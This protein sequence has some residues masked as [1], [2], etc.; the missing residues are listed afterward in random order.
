MK[1]GSI[2]GRTII[3]RSDLKRW[4]ALDHAQLC[5]RLPSFSSDAMPIRVGVGGLV[6]PP[7]FDRIEKIISIACKTDID[8][9]LV[10]GAFSYAW[11]GH[12]GQ[13][14]KSGEPY[15]E[16]PLTVAEIVS[17]WGL[18][19][20]E[21]AA[22]L[23]HDLIE[24]GKIAYQKITRENI[25]EKLGS[26]I[27]ELVEGMTELGKE[28]GF[29]GEKPSEV[30]IYRKLLKHGSKDLGSIIVKLADRLH[31]MRT[32]KSAKTPEEKAESTLYVYRRIADA[33]GMW[34]LKR[35]FEDL[36]FQWLNPELYRKIEEKRQQVEES[37]PRIEKIAIKLKKKYRATPRKVAL[38]TRGIYEIHERMEIRKICIEEL[39]P[40]DIWRINFVVPKRQDCY[41][42]LGVVHEL[43]MHDP[44]EFIDHIAD[45]CANGHQFIQTYIEVPGYSVEK[46]PLR[47]LV[48]IRDEKMQ[49]NYRIGVLSNGGETE[50][51]WLDIL[52][53]YLEGESGI[54]TGDLYGKLTD[55]SA[56]MINVTTRTGKPLRFSRGSTALDFAARINEEVFLHAK[57]A[58]VNG[59][60]RNLSYRLRNG[61]SVFI[62]TDEQSWPALEWTEWIRGET[63]FDLL[64]GALRCKLVDGIKVEKTEEEIFLSAM[65]YFKEKLTTYYLPALQLLD[66]ELFKEFLMGRGIES[67]EDFLDKVGKGGVKVSNLLSDFMGIYHEA[68]EKS[69]GQRTYHVIITAE[70]RKGLLSEIITPLGRSVQVNL[71]EV[72]SRNFEKDGRIMAKIMITVEGAAGKAGEVQQLQ[73]RTIAEMPDGVKKPVHFPTPKE[74]ED[75]KKGKV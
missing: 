21:V 3:R 11:V 17:E 52:L 72:V 15:L 73:V 36:S 38:E 41:R 75:F 53:R 29:K 59:R 56:Q 35:E 19:A 1:T 18:G 34:E 60:P 37:R 25:E 74:I 24:D 43:Y 39:S 46:P 28:P 57:T 48:Q 70:D 23:C 49:E 69:E 6:H 10:R 50:A 32:L 30:E 13:I 68:V 55:V 62:I 16:H 8:R 4:R 7:Y 9:E 45:V 51:V 2:T 20:E 5:S 27:A 61:D 71:S 47:L 33:L 40:S 63:A 66:A 22:A 14:R 31:N 26:R 12:G 67:K 44:K 42:V 65:K 58:I 54:A 64:K